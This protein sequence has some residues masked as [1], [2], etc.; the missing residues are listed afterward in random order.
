MT[1]QF[2]GARSLKGPRPLEI[3]AFFG[4]ALGGSAAC[5]VNPATGARQLSLVS[6]SQEIEMG[7]QSAAEVRS[8]IGLYPDS[9]AQAYVSTIGRKIAATTERPNLPWSFQIVEDPAVNAFALPGGFVFVTRGILTHLNSEAELATVIGHEIGH[10]TAR[11]SVQQISRAEIAQLGIGIGSVVSSDVA[12][13]SDVLSGGLN[14]LMLKYSRDAE[15]QADQLGFRYGLANNY[16]VRAMGNLF[17]TLQRVTAASGGGRVPQWLATHPDPENRYANT[18]ARVKAVTNKD[19]NSTILNRDGYLRHTESMVYGDNPR[20]GYFEGNVFVHPDLRFRLDFPLGW[21]TQNQ[22]QAVVAISPSQDAIIELSQE[23]QDNPQLALQQFTQKQSLQTGAMANS[24][25]NGMA[26][27]EADFQGQSQNGPIRG[28]VVFLSYG[29]ATYR[30][31]AY[32]GG[33]Q[34]PGYEP[35]M[36]QAQGSFARLTDPAALNKQP[37]RVHLVRLSRDMSLE[38]FYRT[39]PSVVP[40]EQIGIINAVQPGGL[41]KAGAWIKRVQ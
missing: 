6:E 21:K 32:A 12:R 9:S 18:E 11:H 38:E 33:Q 22:A 28:R 39:Y 31:L 26:A 36:H 2:G 16:D 34:F 14:I 10:V 27:S 37:N 41:L 20:Q 17:Q 1:D 23:G 7:Q 8:S 30:L 13:Y 15:N 3:L 19:W 29:G 40:I 4:L 24:A 25:I 5:A 35:A